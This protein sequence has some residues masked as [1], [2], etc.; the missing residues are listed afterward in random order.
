M[1]TPR[2]LSVGDHVTITRDLENA[3]GT[4]AA[5]HRFQIIDIHFHGG[6]TQYDLR[7]HELHLLG[8]VPQEDVVRAD[9][10]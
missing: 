9:P 5:G 10:D 1:Y 3:E 6:A 2:G 7:D 4:F 8:D